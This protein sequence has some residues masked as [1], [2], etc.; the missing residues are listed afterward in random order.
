M[1]TSIY[2]IIFIDKN[3][4]LHAWFVLLR[5]VGKFLINPMTGVLTVVGDL[6]E[7]GVNLYTLTVTASNNMA[8]TSVTPGTVRV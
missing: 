5:A 2:N 6:D 7:E 4:H 3:H 8:L 1:L